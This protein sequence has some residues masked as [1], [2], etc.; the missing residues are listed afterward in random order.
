MA[1][2]RASAARCC[3]PRA[4]GPGPAGL[5]GGCRARRAA[6]PCG[7]GACRDVA[8]AS[9]AG[10][11]TLSATVMFESRLKNWNTKP[12][13]RR[14]SSA[15]CGGGQAVHAL[16]V[17]ARSRRWSLVPAR[18]AGAAGWTSRPGRTHDRDELADPDLDVHAAHG[19][20][21]DAVGTVNLGQRGRPQQ[22][23][24]STPSAPCDPS[25]PSVPPDP[26]SRG[27]VGSRLRPG[28][29]TP[30]PPRS[31]PASSGPPPG[32]RWHPRSAAGRWCRRA[33]YLPAVRSGPAA[34]RDSCRRCFLIGSIRSASP[35]MRGEEELVEELVADPRA[36]ARPLDPDGERVAARRRQLVTR[37]FGLV[38]CSTSS[39]RTSPSCSRRFRVT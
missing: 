27:P 4:A 12:M 2:A 32:A 21:G 1:S 25:T 30:A 8:P 35:A 22:A 18:R 38:A 36:L 11:S 26:S 33:R 24:P 37:L 29:L 19:L 15:Q 9:S 6:L 34:G 3:S 10:S 23:G 7:G 31:A 5:V 20:R 28:Q 13:W 16:P 17:A 14:R 39:L